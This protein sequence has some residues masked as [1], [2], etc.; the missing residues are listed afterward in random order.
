MISML[1]VPSP[2]EN[3]VEL[4]DPVRSGPFLV[5]VQK[6]CENTCWERCG[7]SV[8]AGYLQQEGIRVIV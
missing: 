3:I 2:P 4:L 6:Q 5:L 8:G 1:V 7:L